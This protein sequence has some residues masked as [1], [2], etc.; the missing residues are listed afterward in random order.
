MYTC[1]S[2]KEKRDIHLAVKRLAENIVYERL[3][4]LFVIEMCKGRGEIRF[5]EI[6]NVVEKVTVKNSEFTEKDVNEILQ[7]ALNSIIEYFSKKGYVLNIEKCGWFIENS[8]IR[9][10]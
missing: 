8:A 2:E 7:N 5:Y 6:I 3:Y 9:I 4:N 10:K 1:I